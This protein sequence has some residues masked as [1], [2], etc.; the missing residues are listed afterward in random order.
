MTLFI[1]VILS[2]MFI[3]SATY[4]MVIK[5]SNSSVDDDTLIITSET[6]MITFFTYG[7]Q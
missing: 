5:V 1:Y 7:L 6:A 2:Q 4:Y 3:S